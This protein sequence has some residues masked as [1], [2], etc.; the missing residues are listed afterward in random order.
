MTEI[1][2]KEQN[3][4]DL[5][6][7]TINANLYEKA[8]RFFEQTGTGNFEAILPKQ[9][10]HELK[11]LFYTQEQINA[12]RATINAAVFGNKP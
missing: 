6:Q 9:C 5:A 10:C 12:L 8:E 11:R 2:N 7:E 3:Y 1:E 4:D